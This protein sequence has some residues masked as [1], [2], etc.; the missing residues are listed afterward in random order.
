MHQTLMKCRMS[1]DIDWWVD[2]WDCSVKS[3]SQHSTHHLSRVMAGYMCYCST[4]YHFQSG[5]QQVPESCWL[6]CF[7]PFC[8]SIYSSQAKQDCSWLTI[9][10]C[11]CTSCT[12][13]CT[14]HKMHWGL[15]GHLCDIMCN[16]LVS[17]GRGGGAEVA[18]TAQQ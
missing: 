14:S 13:L 8:R 7:C 3:C 6:L 1:K 15:S 4:E 5:Q 11:C 12:Y 10:R 18:N 2:V 16:V 9:T 17:Q